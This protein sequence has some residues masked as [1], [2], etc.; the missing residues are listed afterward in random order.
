MF[1]KD[2]DFPLLLE[3]YEKIKAFAF[4][5]DLARYY[6]MYKFSGLYVDIDSYCVNNVKK[7]TSEFDL[8]IS[9]DCN[10]SNISQAFIYSGKPRLEI[11][12]QL[13]ESCITNILNEDISDGDVGVTGPKLFGKIAEKILGYSSKGNKFDF[14]NLK[15]KIMN[16]Y[17]NLPLPKGPWINSSFGHKVHAYKLKTICKSSSGN[18]INIVTFIPTDTLEN[19]NGH[20]RGNTKVSY[21]LT[22][23][24]GFYVYGGI[25]YAISKYSGYNQ[26]RHVLG[27][28]DFAEIFKNKNIF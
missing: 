4:K 14:D 27:G 7:L 5:A 23:G 18:K 1:K 19:V 28:N 12:K 20:I 26:E 2:Y 16:Y 21:D 10:K 24:S 13:I 22:E 9:Y 8:V 11:F 6:L 3:A 25:I 15:I 17:L